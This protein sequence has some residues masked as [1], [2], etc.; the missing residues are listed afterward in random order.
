MP[1]HDIFMQRCIELALCGASSVSPNPMVGAVVVVDGQIIGEGYH[2]EYGEAHAEVNA[3]DAVINAYPDAE[4]KLKKATIYINLEPCA[5]FGKTPPCSDLIIRYGIP[6]VVIGCR[7]P[8]KQVDGKGIDKLK[9]AG[10][11]V[12]ESVLEKECL[13]LNRRFFT[14]VQKQRPY[15]IL[16]WAQTRDRYFAPADGS[17]RWISSPE[18]KKMVHKWRSEE[19][20]VLVG[21]N[22]AL[23]DNPQLNVRLWEGINPVRIVIDRNLQLPET[24]NLFNQSQ[25][26]IVF[27]SIKTEVI[28]RVKYLELENFD[29]YL[30]Q[31]ICYQLYLMDI[32]SVL[33]EGG[34][35]TLKLFINS[36]LWDEARVFTAES[37]WENGMPAPTLP[38]KS[39]ASQAVGTDLLQIW[40]NS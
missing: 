12:I 35:E 8:F 2:H 37:T 33:V 11:K 17:K 23:I 28:G 5:H 15:I 34:V 13:F 29:N 4:E 24:L 26:T 3:I 19:D 6:Q 18:S 21:K 7:D 16:K 10:L 39:V 27:N 25:P 20:A 30:P 1:G 38:G 9:N 40:F 32:Q 31:L 22:T 14:R 36:G